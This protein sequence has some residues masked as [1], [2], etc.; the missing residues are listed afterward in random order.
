MCGVS[1]RRLSI[2]KT[3]NCFKI[4]LLNNCKKNIHF[5]IKTTV[6][7]VVFLEIKKIFFWK[8]RNQYFILTS[9]IESKNKIAFNFLY[10]IKTLY[11]FVV[12][13]VIQMNFFILTTTKKNS[14]L[15]AYRKLKVILFFFY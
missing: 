7:K 3:Y 9:F 6:L 2:H 8:S 11:F 15:I 13:L 10:L 12:I 14:V 1:A 4:S 5:H